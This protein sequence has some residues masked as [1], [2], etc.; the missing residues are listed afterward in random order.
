M[1][2]KMER[3]LI[4]FVTV[5]LLIFCAGQTLCE[6][7][8]TVSNSD[9]EQFLSNIEEIRRQVNPK[10]D[11]HAFTQFVIGYSN[12]FR[13]KELKNRDIA[14]IIDYSI[15]SNRIRLFVLDLKSR[16]TVFESLVAHG[17]NS[18]NEYAKNFSNKRGSKQS[19]LGF[20]ITL[21][22]YSGKHGY[23]LRLKGLEKNINGNA[24]LRDIV[25]HGADYVS[26][27]FIKKYG[28]LGRSWGCP[29][30]PL[31]SNQ[32]IIDT[33]KDGTLL[34]IYSKNATNK[35]FSKYRLVDN[36]TLNAFCMLFLDGRNQLIESEILK[37]GTVNQAVVFPR[38][39]VERALYHHAVSVIVAHNHPSGALEPSQEDRDITRAI[40]EALK[41]VDITL[42]DHIIIG[43][44]DYCSLKDKGQI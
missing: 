35:Q 2:H 44:N 27:D 31:K 39:I 9:Y 16:Q 34:F 12:L 29:A 3:L 7:L 4:I 36:N 6:G 37:T 33:I 24:L 11:S 15:S 17:R 30:L 1:G 42:L 21:N 10:I 13:N 19:S 41:T 22:T 26:A 23:S 14:T 20:F 25:I 28:R 5:V 40:K 38:K 43:V 8:N 32:A 18:G